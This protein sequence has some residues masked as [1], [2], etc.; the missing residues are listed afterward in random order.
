MKQIC[1]FSY[2][3]I[4]KP[5]V[6][7][8]DYFSPHGN[9]IDLT[10]ARKIVKI[11]ATLEIIKNKSDCHMGTLFSLSFYFPILMDL[12]VYLSRLPFSSLTLA[13]FFTL[14]LFPFFVISLLSF[15]ISPLFPPSQSLT[16]SFSF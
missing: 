9:K 6:Y 11:C 12:Y 13:V 16:F 2:L 4:C 1:V 8:S 10:V 3:E 5:V 14:N 15:A 7:F